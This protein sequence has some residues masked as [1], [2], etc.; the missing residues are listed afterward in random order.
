MD[1]KAF[2][3]RTIIQSQTLSGQRPAIRQNPS[4][5]QDQWVIGLDIGYSSVKGMSQNALFTFPKFAK[6]L[7]K[8]A[9]ALA[10]PLDTDI[11]YRDENGE[12][13]AVGEKAEKMLSIETASDNDPTL[14]GRNLITVKRLKS[15]PA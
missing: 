14:F 6:K 5:R 9:V 12:I 4:R 1:T 13:Y 2:K 8:N 10:K 11:L 15:P 7:P 3:T